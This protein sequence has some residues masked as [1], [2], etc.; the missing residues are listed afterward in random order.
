MKIA[1]DH[2]TYES[3]GTPLGNS[4]YE[5]IGIVN[6]IGIA[7]DKENW[8]LNYFMYQGESITYEGVKISLLSTGDNDTVEISRVS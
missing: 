4:K 6:G 8:D 5:G 7:G 1:N 2:G 3:I